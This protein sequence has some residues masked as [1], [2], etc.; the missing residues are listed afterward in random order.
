MSFEDSAAFNQ[1][2]LFKNSYFGILLHSTVNPSQI[3]FCWVRKEETREI[4]EGNG[5]EEE[6]EFLLHGWVITEETAQGGF[7][8]Y[9][10]LQF[11]VSKCGGSKQCIAYWH[12][13]SNLIYKCSIDFLEEHTIPLQKL[14]PCEEFF[15]FLLFY[16][17]SKGPITWNGFPGYRIYYSIV[18]FFSY[19]L[20]WPF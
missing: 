11:R 17:F 19:P 7:F 1:Q 16:S 15:G 13:C 18:L 20:I 9:P 2:V 14:T 6:G 8:I 3:I 5:A 10:E 4:R 12:L